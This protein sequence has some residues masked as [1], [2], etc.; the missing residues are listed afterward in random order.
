MNNLT[1]TEAAGRYDIIIFPNGGKECIGHVPS[2]PYTPESAYLNAVVEF[3]AKHQG[4]DVPT[5]FTGYYSVKNG[6]CT[7]QW[8]EFVSTDESEEQ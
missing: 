8:Y 3:V 7:M 5:K 6:V 2:T 1:D 4:L